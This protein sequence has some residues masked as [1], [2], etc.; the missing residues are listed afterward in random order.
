M[1]ETKYMCIYCNFIG[2]SDWGNQVFD[3][4]IVDSNILIIQK[5][6]NKKIY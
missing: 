6:I 1:S 3:N 5:N 2:T 4:A